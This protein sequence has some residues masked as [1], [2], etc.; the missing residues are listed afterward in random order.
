[1]SERR[2]LVDGLKAQPPVN[3]GIEQQFVFGDKRGHGSEP[4][5][6]KTA[7]VA[8]APITS[9]IRADYATALKRASLERQLNGETPNTLQEILEEAVGPW[10]KTHGYL[11]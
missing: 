6:P 9:K 11:P 7:A 2:P 3:P 1:V 10:L 4:P 8:R 5:V